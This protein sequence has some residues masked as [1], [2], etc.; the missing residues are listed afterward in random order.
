MGF[1]DKVKSK[2]QHDKSNTNRMM[3]TEN[4]KQQFDV[5]TD[6]KP[7]NRMMDTI[8]NEQSAEYSEKK[9]FGKD[10]LDSNTN[11][12]LMTHTLSNQ[13][14]EYIA[15]KGELPPDE[16]PRNKLLDITP[17]GE[18]PDNTVPGPVDNLNS[19]RVL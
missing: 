19:N 7:R 2:F 13:D 5:P 10:D 12:H 15:N 16:A 18:N 14:A 17:N 4:N 8:S 6:D 1:L 11:K 9:K 3:E